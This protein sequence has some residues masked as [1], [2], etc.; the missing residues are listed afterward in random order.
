MTRVIEKCGHEA[1]AVQD[2]PRE[3]HRAQ[4]HRAADGKVD[5][6]GDHQ[7]RER[8]A[9][10]QDGHRAAQEI[11]MLSG[12]RK[13]PPSNNSTWPSFTTL[14]TATIRTSTT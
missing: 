12:L 4:A 9:E 2:H 8:A 13:C 5:V 1:D 10:G 14:K 11:E 3:H 7:Q 6:A